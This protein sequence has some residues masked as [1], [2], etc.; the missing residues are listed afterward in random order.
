MK[1]TPNIMERL[2]QT[3]R[4]VFKLWKDVNNDDI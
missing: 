4:S 3:E 2:Q 1:N